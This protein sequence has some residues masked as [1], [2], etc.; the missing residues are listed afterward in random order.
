MSDLRL[1]ACRRFKKGDG[2]EWAGALLVVAPDFD[3]AKLIFSGWE[4]GNLPLEIE[5]V[6]GVT[7]TGEPR[8]VYDDYT[9]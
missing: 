9:R 5:Q 3:S 7:A 8:I 6:D 4:R 1:W 2:E